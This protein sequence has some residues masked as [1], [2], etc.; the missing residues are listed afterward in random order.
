MRT[1]R[2]GGPRTYVDSDHSVSVLQGEIPV[3]QS[4]GVRGESPMT[5]KHLIE[6]VIIVIVVYL[7]VRMFR[8]RD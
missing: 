2:T 7:A 4:G 3:A 8:K 5:V 6:I 1:S